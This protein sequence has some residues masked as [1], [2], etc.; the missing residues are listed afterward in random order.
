MEADDIWNTEVELLSNQ[1]DVNER[2]DQLEKRLFNQ[3]VGL[4][5]RLLQIHLREAWAPE[6]Y[7]LWSHSE[8]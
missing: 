4:V 8:L 1:Y 6:R 2:M 7:D 3:E 5:D